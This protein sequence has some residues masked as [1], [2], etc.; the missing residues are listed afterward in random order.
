MNGWVLLLILTLVEGIVLLGAALAW[1]DGLAWLRR[2]LFPGGA[3]QPT[4]EQFAQRMI[5]A[6]QVLLR[7][8][9]KATL[10]GDDAQAGACAAALTGLR[11][12]AERFRA[13]PNAAMRCGLPL[14]AGCE[15]LV[16]ALE[17]RPD[18]APAQSPAPR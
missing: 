8:S 5:E 4:H 13:E 9:Q 15:Q 18:A 14:L 10:E 3:E 12:A 6:Y 7:L 11:Q 16:Q 1:H 17:R 2:R